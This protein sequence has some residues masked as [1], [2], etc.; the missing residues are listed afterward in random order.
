MRSVASPVQ[1]ASCNE[2]INDIKVR[3]A[4]ESRSVTVLLEFGNTFPC[5]KC[6][7]SLLL[8]RSLSLCLPF[9][10]TILLLHV[11]R[12]LGSSRIATKQMAALIARHDMSSVASESHRWTRANAERTGSQEGRKK[13]EEKEKKNR[14]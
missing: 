13:G 9:P 1:I 14:E 8:S 6:Y 11:T 7:I 10:Y 12:A 5:L 4:T 2:N 3:N